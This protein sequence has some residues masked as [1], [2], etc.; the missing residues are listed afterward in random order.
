[1]DMLSLFLVV[2]VFISWKFDVLNNT[3]LTSLV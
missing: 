3:M 2:N 1:M